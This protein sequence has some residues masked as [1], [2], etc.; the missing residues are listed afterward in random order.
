M[1]QPLTDNQTVIFELT[2][3]ESGITPGHSAVFNLNGM[4]VLAYRGFDN[5]LYLT[6]ISDLPASTIQ[7]LGVDVSN[8]QSTQSMILASMTGGLSN[9]I[10]SGLE[11]VISEAK[12]VGSTASDIASRVA[13]AIP[14]LITGTLDTVGNIADMVLIGAGLVLLIILFKK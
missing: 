5:V 10:S 8:A 1:P 9:V 13:G 7:N 12:T 6:N 11:T 2:F 14:G 4:M 3:D